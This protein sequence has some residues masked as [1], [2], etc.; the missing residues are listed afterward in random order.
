M[1]NGNEMIGSGVASRLEWLS[2]TVGLLCR[3][4]FDGSL[5]DLA[6]ALDSDDPKMARDCGGFSALVEGGG[7][8]L[9]L[10]AGFLAPR[11]FGAAL[12]FDPGLGR[13]FEGSPPTHWLIES[14]VRSGCFDVDPSLAM[15]DVLASWNGAGF[16]VDARDGNGMTGA[17]K[18]LLH[19]DD[20]ALRAFLDAGASVSESFSGALMSEAALSFFMFEEFSL[21][22]SRGAPAPRRLFG[23]LEGVSPSMGG[24]KVPSLV[25]MMEGFEIGRSTEQVARPRSGGTPS[26]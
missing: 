24:G 26:A 18:A 13:S 2:R 25:A 19:G 22:A 20:D 7:N 14:K 12:A 9:H 4:P 23:P 11:V 1:E 5:E 10:A 6:L 15:A 21:L 17:F 16:D 8:V 3:K